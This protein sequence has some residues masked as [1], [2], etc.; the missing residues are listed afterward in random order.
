MLTAY[1]DENGH[2]SQEHV[3]VAGHVGNDSQWKAFLEQWVPAR[4]NRK[5]IHLSALRWSN[6]RTHKLLA[7]L[8]PIP[9]RC[10][11]TRAVGGVRVSDY[12]DLL[13]GSHEQKALK[14]YYFA[15]NGLVTQVT[16]WIPDDERIEFVFE[17]QRRY[18]DT[19]SKLISD[20]SKT[21]VNSHGKS[22]IANWSF[23]PKGSTVLLEQ[24]DYL[25]NALGHLYRDQNSDKSIWTKSIL[26]DMT[27]IGAITK[28]KQI[29]EVIKLGHLVRDSG[30][31]L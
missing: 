25:A 6:P 28:R 13:R 26:G 17:D 30:A 3:F 7:A 31:V 9:A 19:A 11:L 15:L 10:N 14:G 24:A 29:R 2:E 23:V 18:R 27:G 21:L 1:L 20:F 4:G 22:K 5:Q 12:A 16:R 8:G